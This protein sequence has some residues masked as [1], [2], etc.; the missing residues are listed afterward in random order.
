MDLHGLSPKEKMLAVVKSLFTSGM[1]GLAYVMHEVLLKII[2]NVKLGLVDSYIVTIS[3]VYYVVGVLTVILLIY[4]PLNDIFML[5]LAD[6][7][8]M[9]GS[10]AAIVPTYLDGSHALKLAF[11][12]ISKVLL[13]LAAGI[14]TKIVPS[15]LSE[16]TPKKY[17]KFALFSHLATIA[18]L[19]SLVAL[20]MF[21]N[22]KPVYLWFVIF[23]FA[24]VNMF[25]KIFVLRNKKID[26]QRSTM[27][28]NSAIKRIVKDK[29]SLLALFVLFTAH[30]TYSFSGINQIL[31]MAYKKYL[32]TVLNSY[33]IMGGVMLIWSV[34]SILFIFVIKRFPKHISFLIS[35]VRVE[36]CLLA[37]YFNFHQIVFSVLYVISLHTG[38]AFI[39]ILLHKKLFPPEYN[40]HADSISILFHWITATLSIV[41]IDVQGTFESW[42]YIVYMVSVA[43]GTVVMLAFYKK[44][45]HVF[46]APTGF[47]KRAI[48]VRTVS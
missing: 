15:F 12:A 10:V 17:K 31:L 6:C 8:F 13:G 16:I 47:R 46:P 45:K 48:H 23:S 30:F 42:S 9:L 28:F 21:I 4:V 38:L 2:E 26:R 44:A 40:A 5:H 37:L 7:L 29:S 34:G 18:F 41:L 3:L 11:A 22:T 19:L 33:I 39:P 27:P 1:T 32:H 20:M 35:S 25:L 43:F 36:L 24:V 14:L